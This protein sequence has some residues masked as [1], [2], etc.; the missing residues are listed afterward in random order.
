MMRKY[1]P[2][3][4]VFCF[5]ALAGCQSAAEM[6]AV[7]FYGRFNAIAGKE[8]LSLDRTVSEKAD[9]EIKYSCL[10]EGTGSPERFLL[11]MYAPSEGGNV[12]SCHVTMLFQPNSSDAAAKGIP[13]EFIQVSKT[14][15]EAFTKLSE[16]KA[17][18]M[19]KELG[20]GVSQPVQYTTTR[21]EEKLFRYSL[22]VNDVGAT[23]KIENTL[24]CPTTVPDLTLR[25]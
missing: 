6:N 24:L 22:I 25:Q 2:V 3:V 19:L 14:A 12:F 16:E 17:G 7:D 21:K 5:V 18:A 10:F 13:E 9:K 1:I 23:L 20:A 4:L 11:T 8:T 15:I